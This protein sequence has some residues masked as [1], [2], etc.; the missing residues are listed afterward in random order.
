MKHY[1]GNLFQLLLSPGNGWEDI[2]RANRDP[3][4]LARSG[5]YPLCL[6][7]AVSAWAD[8]VYHPG[9]SVWTLLLRSLVIFVAFF[10]GYFIATF[11]LAV[12]LPRLCDG[13]SRLARVQTFA[14]YVLGLLALLIVTVSWL[15]MAAVLLVFMPLYVAL[16]IWKGTTYMRILPDRVPAFMIL[17]VAAVMLPPLL[18]YL[19]FSM[20]I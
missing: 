9:L 2:A 14:L 16:I 20:I 12:F 4:Y 18:I 13:K 10:L 3:L 7:A 11:C 19:F 17:A 5:F 1:L 15:P 8:A 6:A